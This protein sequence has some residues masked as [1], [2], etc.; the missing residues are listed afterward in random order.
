MSD[1]SLFRLGG[2]AAF[3]GGALGLVTL[4]LHAGPRRGDTTKFM[5]DVA[6]NELWAID[7]VGIIV[8]VLLL[9]A[10]LFAIGRSITGDEAAPWASIGWTAAVIGAVLILANAAVD[11]PAMKAVAESWTDASGPDKSALFAA[12]EVLRQVD[13][14]GFA[15]WS[16]V[17]VGLTPLLYGVAVITSADYPRWIGWVAVA[18]GLVGIVEGVITFFHGLIWLTVFV[19][20]PTA[21]FATIAWIMYMGWL[22]LRRARVETIASYRGR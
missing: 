19:L 20:A 16:L 21:V 15:L 2:W 17:L 13:V 4:F 10:A 8:A 7:H 12:A 9:L 22:L 11:G 6:G 1:S 3:S 14:A 18:V 5:L